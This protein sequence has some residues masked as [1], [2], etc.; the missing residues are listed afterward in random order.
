MIKA[1][2]VD[3][4]AESRQTLSAM[5][6]RYCP[7][8]QVLGQ[9]ADTDS[10]AGSIVS[11][12]PD[13]VFMDISLP[14]KSGLLFLQEMQDISFEVI[15]VTAHQEYA[16]QAMR[17]SAVDYLLKPV[18]T[19]ELTRAIDSAAKRL[20]NKEGQLQRQVLLHNL[21]RPDDVAK[22]MCIPTIKGFEVVGLD[23][24]IYAEAENSYTILNLKSGEKIVSSRTLLDYENLLADAGFIRIHRS[25]LININYIRSYQKGEGG[26]VTM[27]NGMEI[28][29][30]RRK[31]DLFLEKVGKIFRLI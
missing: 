17:L 31:K 7:D 29:V 21:N 30:S 27:S 6:E 13:L 14:G 15:F 22:K 19:N 9:Y 16:L 18:Q 28:D 12:P 25:F 3:D 24:I 11:N 5:L 8:V 23:E 4:E 1:V 10:F 26:V 2:I 20:T